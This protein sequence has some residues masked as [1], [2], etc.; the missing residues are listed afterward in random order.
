MVSAVARYLIVDRADLATGVAIRWIPPPGPLRSDW[1]D[2]GM[3]LVAFD[4]AF[5]RPSDA[6]TTA[7]SPPQPTPPPPVD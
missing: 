2:H 5:G 6:T 4:F 1:F 7:S 3:L